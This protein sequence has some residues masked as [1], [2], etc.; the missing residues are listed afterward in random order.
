MKKLKNYLSITGHNLE[1]SE[2]TA[3]KNAFDLVCIPFV[4]ISDKLQIID[5]NNCAKDLLQINLTSEITTE[6]SLAIRENSKMA[7]IL[8]SNGALITNHSIQYNN[9]FIKWE[10]KSI[11]IN[12]APY[13]L[14]LGI[15]TTERESLLNIL[16]EQAENAIGYVNPNKSDVQQYINQISNYYTS[17]IEKIPCYI[18]WKNIKLEYLGCNQLAAS[19]VRLKSPKDIIGKTDFDIFIDHELAKSY[20]DADKEILSMGKSILNQLG[21]LTNEDGE[22]FYTLVSKAPI[23]DL[24][25]NIIG[26]VGITVD[27]TETEKA[28]ESAESSLKSLQQAQKEEQKQR[29]EAERLAIENAAHKAELDTQAKFITVVNRIAHDVAGSMGAIKKM[30]KYFSNLKEITA[31]SGYDMRP[32][33]EPTRENSTIYIQ[34]NESG[35]V[36][37]VLDSKNELK[38]DEV[39]WEQLFSQLKQD[40]SKAEFDFPEFQKE[41]LP[42]LLEYTEKLGLTKKKMNEKRLPE[43]QRIQLEN[44]TQKAMTIMEG[45]LSKYLNSEENQDEPILAFNPSLAIHDAF[46]ETRLNYENQQI[47]FMEEFNPNSQMVFIE[48]QRSQINRAITNLLRNAAQA[49]DGKPGDV[50]LKLDSDEFYVYITI[51][52][53][54]KGMPPEM[55]DKIKNNIAFTEGKKDGHGIGLGQ[56][57]AT[58]NRNFAEL[59]IISEI[60]KGTQF[61]I[62]FKK[63][64]PPN[65]AA[66]T[67]KITPKDKI[68][69]VDDDPS[70]HGDWGF[71]FE[72][73]I[74]KYPSISVHNF[75]ESQKALDYI[76]SLPFEEQKN[77]ML[78]SDFEL[79]NDARNG[80]NVI[81]ESK[82]KRAFL[83]TSHCNEPDIQQA[84]LKL[85]AKLLP[86]KLNQ[87]IPIIVIESKVEYSE[88]NLK[89]VDGIWLDDDAGFT[90]MHE[91]DLMMNGK[92][93]D[94]YRSPE[95]LM[96]NIRIYPKNIPILLDNNFESTRIQGT[97]VAL[98]LHNLG[99][100]KLFLVSGDSINKSTYPYLTILSKA[101]L[102]D[103]SK[104]F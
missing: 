38:K 64:L 6:T 47:N 44:S 42:I 81:E 28:K 53:T 16:Q 30:T 86:K 18:Y 33:S 93:V 40:T 103:I 35:L 22:T 17:I 31:I 14:L 61:V 5:V 48:G 83:V 99:F 95:D 27:V 2:I 70:I 91:P 24:Y 73:I 13:F 26:L 9:K 60:G 46:A 87:F 100:T 37:E 45:I 98:E 57:N 55:V 25:G 41:F 76:Q 79:A 67:I 97:A 74:E 104:Y 21:K 102:D 75:Y 82:V 3:Y 84:L 101:D 11:S 77:I 92:K 39:S 85:N 20:Q 19:F 49:L 88:T 58:L 15:D 29:E 32:I 66:Q 8:D 65:W 36:F 94:I 50:I 89:I 54:G 80:L 10:K 62:K 23:S 71:N 12:N 1:T 43:A 51:A 56:V 34:P 4:L 52:D 72:P 96:D 7:Q 90:C 59:D 63:C 78:L 69:V 68:I